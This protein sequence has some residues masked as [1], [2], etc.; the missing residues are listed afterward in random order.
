MGSLPIWLSPDD[1]LDA[2]EAFE[3]D[4]W[5]TSTREAAQAKLRTIQRALTPWGLHPFPP[6]LRTLR[7]LG[8]TLKR[9]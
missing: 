2:L 9:G 7:A 5:A 3:R 6:T 4:S 1:R 8:A